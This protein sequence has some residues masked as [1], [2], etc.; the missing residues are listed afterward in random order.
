MAENE[1]KED[2]VPFSEMS[3]AAGIPTLLNNGVLF[4]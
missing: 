4:R 1:Q 3:T 2:S